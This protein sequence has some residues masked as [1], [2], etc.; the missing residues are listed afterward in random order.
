[1]AL[2]TLV[3]LTLGLHAAAAVV[4]DIE[5][6]ALTRIGAGDLD[7]LAVLHRADVNLVI[8]VQRPWPIGRDE[9]AL[10]AGLGEHQHL[11]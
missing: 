3:R 7:H 11:R 10:Q 6:G 5:H 8:E 4:A 1:M 2:Q 9:L